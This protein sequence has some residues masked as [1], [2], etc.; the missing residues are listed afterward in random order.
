MT[1]V[2]AKRKQLHSAEFRFKNVFGRKIR[3]K[4]ALRSRILSASTEVKHRL[5]SYSPLHFNIKNIYQIRM[6]K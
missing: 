6:E 1:S 3:R 5:G 4:S 2:L